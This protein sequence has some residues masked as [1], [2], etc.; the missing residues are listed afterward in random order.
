MKYKSIFLGTVAVLLCLF[1]VFP[2]TAQQK[3]KRPL[4]AR[5]T[6]GLVNT[7]KNYMI[8]VTPKGKLVTVEFTGKTKI[9]KLVPSKAKADDIYLRA[10]ASITYKKKGGKNVLSSI[11]FE[12]KRR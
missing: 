2:T 7:E 9:T 10:P 1:W 5:G 4:R 3:R 11:K 6:V 8:L 12:A